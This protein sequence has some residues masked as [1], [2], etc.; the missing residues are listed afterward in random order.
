MVL[1]ADSVRRMVIVNGQ[2]EPIPYCCTCKFD[3]I[4]FFFFFYTFLNGISLLWCTLLAFAV[5]P[6]SCEEDLTVWTYIMFSL[7]CLSLLS[8]I[9]MTHTVGGLLNCRNEPQ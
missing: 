5:G 3:I 6:E 7:L 9:F 1:Y 2:P 4:P 8:S